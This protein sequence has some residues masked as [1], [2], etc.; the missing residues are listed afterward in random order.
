MPKIIKPARPLVIAGH[1]E[2]HGWRL[3]QP[4]NGINPC[5]RGPL[6]SRLTQDTL[7]DPGPG[8]LGTDALHKFRDSR[9]AALHGARE[10]HPGSPIR[11]DHGSDRL[12][13]HSAWLLT[14]PHGQGDV[15]LIPARHIVASEIGDRPC[16]S[17]DA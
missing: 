11:V 3:G 13:S 5:C 6:R 9:I 16:Q 7:N 8:G 17:K 15:E 10:Q 1:D 12:T 4:L 14:T 2:T